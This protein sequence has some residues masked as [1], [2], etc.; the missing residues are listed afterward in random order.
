MTSRSHIS[1]FVGF[2]VALVVVAAAATGYFY[3]EKSSYK[4]GIPKTPGGVVFENLLPPDPFLV[5]SYNPTDDSQR[6]ELTRIVDAVFQDKKEA[7]SALFVTEFEKKIERDIAA[8][9]DQDRKKLLQEA[10]SFSKEFYHGDARFTLAMTGEFPFADVMAQK[11]KFSKE[12]LKDIDIYMFFAIKDADKNPENKERVSQLI[13]WM[14]EEKINEMI[15]EKNIMPKKFHTGVLGDVGYI[16]TEDPE[17]LKARFENKEKSFATSGMFHEMG[18]SLRPPFLGYIFSGVVTPQSP[19]RFSITTLHATAEGFRME[20]TTFVDEKRIEE[21]PIGVLFKPYTAYLY[22]K[23]PVE[24]PL[25]FME[26]SGLSSLYKLD[27]E[28]NVRRGIPLPDYSAF[29]ALT[30]FDFREDIL[31]FLDRGMAMVIDDSGMVLPFISFYFDIGPDASK[32]E[33]VMEKMDSSIT[34]QV[35]LLNLD[36]MNDMKTKGGGN[37]PLVELSPLTNAKVGRTAKIYLSRIPKDQVDIPLL[38]LFPDPVEF[39]YGLSNDNLLFFS[40]TPNF[41]TVFA[42]KT[43]KTI[44]SSDFF[45]YI[46]KSDLQPGMLLFLDMQAVVSFI[47]RIGK[48]AE[49][50]RGLSPEENEGFQLIK[51]YIAP[52]QGIIGVVET[53]GSVMKMLFFV[54][55]APQ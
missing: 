27:E 47:E 30:G 46:R 41:D 23:I 40:M 34:T 45:G 9:N 29:K 10:L 35:P 18:T 32:A 36:F 24:R 1:L 44:E 25:L 37:Q 7:L 21:S 51:K 19:E 33:M 6:K 49:K 17:K 39:S 48:L 13:K 55:I 26:F 54:K 5:F 43:K 28:E 50:Y 15:S 2:V 42:D 52:I 16:T 12:Q 14:F 4:N 8:T 53:D 3:W 38:D 22:K 11:E 31:P 20:A